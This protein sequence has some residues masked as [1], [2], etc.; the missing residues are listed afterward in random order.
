MSVMVGRHVSRSCSQLLHSFGGEKFLMTMQ[1]RKQR[2]EN[3]M[4]LPTAREVLLLG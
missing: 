2:E 1:I 3:G 4:V